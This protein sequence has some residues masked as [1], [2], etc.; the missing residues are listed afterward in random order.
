LAVPSACRV[1]WEPVLR[2]RLSNHI[3]R[4]DRTVTG[5]TEKA[6]KLRAIGACFS[7]HRVPGFGWS[8]LA[9][10]VGREILL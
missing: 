1:W 4:T 7:R 10:D 3:S 9:S 8:C 6:S 5:R 2:A